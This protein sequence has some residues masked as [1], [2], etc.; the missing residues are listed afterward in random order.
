[1]TWGGGASNHFFNIKETKEHFSGYWLVCISMAGAGE[2]RIWGTTSRDL[3][4][5][6]SQQN[7]SEV[8]TIRPWDCN[9][10]LVTMTMLLRLPGQDLISWFVCLFFVCVCVFMGIHT[11]V[12]MKVL[13]PVVSCDWMVYARDPPAASPALGIKPYAQL[14]YM[15]SGVWTQ[16]LTLAW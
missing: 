16:S 4:P 10:H 9:E 2:Q 7:T 6:F 15:G 3:S 1:M 5:A 14:F 12:C 11:F 13:K 8:G